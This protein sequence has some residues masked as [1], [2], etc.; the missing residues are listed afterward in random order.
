[1]YNRLFIRKLIVILLLISLAGSFLINYYV[2]ESVS[3]YYIGYILV[4]INHSLIEG[5]L[6]INLGCSSIMFS[7]TIPSSYKVLNTEKDFYTN[8]S[9]SV[10]KTI[11]ILLIS[12]SSLINEKHNMVIMM[13]FI[14]SSILVCLILTTWKYRD[15]RIKAISRIMKKRKTQDI[16]K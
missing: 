8:L 13:C 6:F 14:S 12:I 16:E 10:G 5:E 1:M 7:K 4:F 15:I 3:L 11:G 2:I 9:V